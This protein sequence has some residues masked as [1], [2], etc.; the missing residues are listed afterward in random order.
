MT[1]IHL[2]G[3]QREVDWLK[4]RVIDVESRLLEDHA[5]THDA[6]GSDPIE[7]GDL[8]VSYDGVNYTETADTVEGHYTGIDVELGEQSASIFDNEALLCAVNERLVTIL[9]HLRLVNGVSL[10]PDE[11]GGIIG[12]LDEVIE[13]L[14][15][16]KPVE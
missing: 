13:H 1:P 12:F 3:L 9:L 7:G 11:Q 6:E 14:A 8:G 16:I 5:S 4:R 15:I 2:K 10:E